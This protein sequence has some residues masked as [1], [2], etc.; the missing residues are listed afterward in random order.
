MKSL[1]NQ[2]A[3]SLMVCTLLV[4]LPSSLH[5][6]EPNTNDLDTAINSGDFG[7]YL[8]KISAWLNTKVPADPGSI[9]E[10][11]LKDLL[12]D[13]VF[14]DTLDQRQFI[15]GHGVA[16]LGEFAKADQKNRTLL[17]WFLRDTQTM[18]LYLEAAAGQGNVGA[19]ERLTQIIEADPDAKEGVYLKLAMAIAL[20]PP[21]GKSYGSELPIDWMSRY[22][23]YKAARKNKELFPSFD[24]LSVWDMKWVVAGWSSDRD[25]AWVRQMVSTWRPDLRADTKVINIVS[26]VWRRFSPFPFSDGFVSVMAG[27]G[28][29]GPRSWFGQ[30]TCRAFGL[31]SVALGQPKHSAVAYKSPDPSCEPQPGSSWKICYGRGWHVTYGGRELLT[32]AAARD[33]V[34]LF[35]QIQHLTWLASTVTAK[36]RADAIRGIVHKL[37][38]AIP[39]PGTGPNP[40][41]GPNGE[42]IPIAVPNPTKPQP[43]PSNVPEP[44]FEPKP[45]VIHVEAESFSKS[46]GVVVHDCFTGGKQVYSPKY[47]TNWGTPPRIEYVVE[48]PE[49]GVY[50]L[51]MRTAVVNF[52]Q[53][54][55]VAV[56]TEKPV[57]VKV[58][59]T[60]GLW[61]TTPGVD[62]RLEKGTQTLTLTRPASQRGLALRWFELKSK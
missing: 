16:E 40:A 35:S 9:S 1:K 24:T 34:A 61:G 27:G 14:A 21:G 23:H 37:Q 31:P 3:R 43:V 18:D 55:E 19:L 60:H 54:I 7:G 41:V 39:K 47:G 58:P 11:T 22:K 45:G 17:A 6:W 20:W 5:A 51:T 26:E 62:V 4:L 38:Q 32:E 48:I 36:D 29:C 57:T 46:V 8:T 15:A 52:E 56:G 10:A 2:T 30:T 59:N 28:K 33:Q 49:T 13:P 42:A 50:T 12:K 53:S 25:R 44:P